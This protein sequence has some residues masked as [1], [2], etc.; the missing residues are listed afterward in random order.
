MG[1]QVD[2]PTPP[3]GVLALLRGYQRRWLRGDVIAGVTV[4]AYLVPQVMAYAGI[5]GLS[6]VAGLWASVGPLVV[7][8]ALGSSLLLSSGPESSTA[9]MTGATIATLAHGDPARAASIAAALAVAVGVV[10]LV[11]WLFRLG[12]FADL[13]SHPVLVGYMAGIAVL[14]IVSQ[15]GKV[16]GFSVSGRRPYQQLWSVL[17]HLGQTNVPSL[18]TAA[19]VVGV[20][21]LA[22]RWRPH[23]PMPLIVMVAAALVGKVFDLE[24]HGLKVVGAVPRR[25]PVPGWPSIPMDDVVR[26]LPAALALAIVGYTDN[27]LTARAFSEGEPIDSNREFLALGAANV[28]AGMMR[29]FPVSS[30][31]SR[32]AISAA[33]GGT[34]QVSSIVTMLTVLAAMFLVGPAL[35]H[36]PLAALGGLVIFAATRLVQVGEIRRIARFRRTELALSVVAMLGVLVTDVLVGIA[37]AIGLSILDMLR[38]VAR[39]H[40]AVLGYAPGVP[41][42]HDVEDYPNAV[43][44]P[45]LVVYRYDSPL[46]FANAADFRRRALRAV[47][48]AGPDIRWF[49]L[50]AEGLIEVDLTGIDALEEVRADLVRRGIVFAM[51]RVKH[52]LADDLEAAGFLQRV[53]ADRIFATLPTAV[54]AFHGAA[55]DD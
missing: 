32:T 46:F 6:P 2:A 49:L 30:S 16:L 41:G 44:V 3:A 35:G 20:L 29:G 22:A 37:V 9:L 21:L 18:V 10:C 38:R 23:W 7:Y 12:F 5:A 11:G 14:M 55:A 15:L 54:A 1:E 36:F 50:N 51:A 27:V 25:L 43:T 28:A 48:S 53:G 4:A 19:I 34:T 31:G 45:G 52:E 24:H 42:M 17:R 8:A 40:D 33:V 13:L 39:P 47:A 26:M